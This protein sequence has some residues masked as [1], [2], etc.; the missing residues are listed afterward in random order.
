MTEKTFFSP[1][2][3]D[4]KKYSNAW[5]QIDTILSENNIDF[6]FIPVANDIWARDFMPIQRHDGKFI[7]YCYQPNYLQNSQN[8]YITDC[9]G[10]FLSVI[11]DD[12][13]EPQNVIETNLVIDGGNVIKCI[14]KNGKQCVIM[15]TKVLYENPQLSQLETMS[16][17]ST[18]FDA[19]I[20][21]IP[22]DCEEPFGHSDGMVRALAP[23]KL[24]LNNYAEFAPKLDNVLKMALEPRFEIVQLQYGDKKR[25]KSWCH[26]NYLELSD[27]I[28]VPTA[29][30]ASDKLALRQI[31]S[32][33]GKKCFPVSMASIVAEGG[34]MHCISWTLRG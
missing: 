9:R 14:D 2:L 3:K 28:L 16:A 4:L 24:L 23:G 12:T 8:K 6:G 29:S 19:E 25:D 21:L 20:I 15:T 27:I 10:A 31:E 7:I 5:V 34:A 13:I 17:L 32:L 22:W 18:I 26:I 33:T 1:W 11:S 30:L